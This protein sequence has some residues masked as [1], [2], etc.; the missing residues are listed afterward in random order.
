MFCDP[1][2]NMLIT[3]AVCFGSVCDSFWSTPFKLIP[4]FYYFFPKETKI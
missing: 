3:S 4:I 1:V 2:Y